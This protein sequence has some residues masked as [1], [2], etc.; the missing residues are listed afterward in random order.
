MFSR[1]SA[2]WWIGNRVREELAVISA[3]IGLGWALRWLG[4]ARGLV[5]DM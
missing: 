5:D 3:L 1:L 4:W 2:F